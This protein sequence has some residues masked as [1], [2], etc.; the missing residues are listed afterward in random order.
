[1][2]AP[3]VFVVRS[4]DVSG[5]NNAM[6]ARARARASFKGQWKCRPGLRVARH[7]RK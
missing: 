1:M 7:F 2:D 6:H 3:F 4:R 5:A